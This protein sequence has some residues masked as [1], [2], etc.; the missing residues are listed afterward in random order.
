M[1]LQNADMRDSVETETRG[2]D[3]ASTC[4]A[5]PGQLTSPS[6]STAGIDEH[7]P[8]NKLNKINNLLPN[9][10]TERTEKAH[11]RAPVGMPVDIHTVLVLL[12]RTVDGND[13]SGGIRNDSL[14]P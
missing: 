2:I 5:R 7:E 11:S 9:L 13:G 14:D 4:T 10:I 3:D 12:G 8:G 6:Q 1:S